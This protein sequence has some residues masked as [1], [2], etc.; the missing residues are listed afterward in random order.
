MGLG[1]GGGQVI[2][3][4]LGDFAGD[5]TGD[6]AEKDGLEGAHGMGEDAGEDAA[7]FLGVAVGLGNSVRVGVEG[8]LEFL[9]AL[10]GL[11]FFGG[12]GDGGGGEPAEGCGGEGHP[13]VFI[14]PK[15]GIDALE[16]ILL[17]V[18]D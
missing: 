7:V 16:E 3:V 6:G 1:L 10:E 12:D 18:P 14:E 15:A 2:W 8:A 11:L 5:G 17:D 13:R 4:G 9:E